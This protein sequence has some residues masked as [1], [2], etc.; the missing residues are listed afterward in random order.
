[1]GKGVRKDAVQGKRTYPALVGM[2]ESK[3]RA[4]QLVDEA[5]RSLAPLGPAGG[6]L[7]SLAHFVIERDH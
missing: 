5:C 2:E 7:E 4:R 3:Q 1:M 6:R